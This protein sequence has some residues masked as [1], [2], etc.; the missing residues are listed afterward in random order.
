MCVC[1]YLCVYACHGVCCSW[2][3]GVVRSEKH[4]MSTPRRNQ[5]RELGHTSSMLSR[6][7]TLF[8]SSRLYEALKIV[9]WLVYNQDDEVERSLLAEQNS[10][11]F[12][13]LPYS[14]SSLRDV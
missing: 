14:C 5:Q 8:C 10:A 6:T 13:E 9:L 3:K 4:A 7:S 1:M 2:S 11:L 12:G